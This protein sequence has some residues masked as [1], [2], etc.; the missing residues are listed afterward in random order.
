MQPI[1]IIFILI[2]ALTFC[3]Y[4]IDKRKAIKSKWRVSERTL[5]FF[6]LAFGGIGAVLGMYFAKH[7]TKNTKFRIAAILGMVIILIAVV[8][9]WNYLG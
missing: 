6:T 7:K 3:L 5:I 2:N 4:V 8:G 1:I 9:C